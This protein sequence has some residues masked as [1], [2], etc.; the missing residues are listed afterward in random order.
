MAKNPSSLT[1][2]AKPPPPGHNGHAIYNEILLS[3]PAN[4]SSAVFAHLE[5]VDLPTH[6]IG[7]ELGEPIKDCYFPNSGLFSIL[8]VLRDGKSVEVGLTGK[9]GFVGLPLVVGLKT[10][11]ARAIVQIAATGF[12]IKADKMKDVLRQCPSLEKS[13]NRYA[14]ALA[15]QS[16]QV[17]AC[18][19]LHEVEERLSRWLLMCQDRI[20]GDNV[21]LTQDFL[22]HMLGTR[23][24]SVTVAAGILQKA[25]LI[26]YNRG[27]VHIVNRKNLEDAACECYETIT[28]QVRNWKT[29]AQ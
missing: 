24:A 13:L 4:E 9:E 14:Q 22:A 6:T 26:T 25:G 18:N 3:L 5:F 10:S 16:I 1:G 21:P 7:N 2:K 11:A 20:G 28:Q 17:A 12:R 27:Q 19:R 23:R 8:S 29:E 15:V